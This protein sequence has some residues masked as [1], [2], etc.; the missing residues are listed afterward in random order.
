MLSR[1]SSFWT[2]CRSDPGL[3]CTASP[4]SILRRV[5]SA[6]LLY[7]NAYFN[8]ISDNIYLQI[9]SLYLDWYITCHR[10]WFCKQMTDMFAICLRKLV[11]LYMACN[12]PMTLSCWLNWVL[13]VHGNACITDF[14]TH[15][16]TSEPYY[17]WY[18]VWILHRVS[19]SNDQTTQVERLILVFKLEDGDG[20][21]PCSCM[22]GVNLR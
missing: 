1:G 18:G 14:I 19:G 8:A 5:D 20:N 10:T 13:I 16:V 17:R 2:S 12:I 6:P 11:P 22:W 9:S 7:Q 3:F 15:F 4:S 21:T